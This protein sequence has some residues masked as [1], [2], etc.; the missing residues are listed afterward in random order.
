MPAA[1]VPAVGLE[2]RSREAPP[3]PERNPR[4]HI[5][6]PLRGLASLA[7]AWFHLAHENPAVSR[8]SLLQQSGSYGWIGV[9]AFFVISGFVIPF[10]LA[11]SGYT[12]H[13]YGR[14]LL[15]RVVRL[16]P[17]YFVAITV[18]LLIAIYG[19]FAMGQGVFPFTFRQILLHFG[20]L[21]VFFHYEWLNP[22]FWTLAVE[23]E[24]YVLI[25]LCFP[26]LR[27]VRFVWLVMAPIGLVL[28]FVP[29]FEFHVFRYLPFFFLG[30]AAYHVKMDRLPTP[31]FVLMT[32]TI[33]V[34]ASAVFGWPATI[35]ALLTSW[36]IVFLKGAPRPLVLLGSISYS[37]YLLHGPIG[38]TVSS[39]LVRRVPGLPQVVTS[40]TALA[41]SMVG[42]W[43][44]FR[45]V[46][47]PSQRLSGRIRYTQRLS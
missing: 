47:R 28:A 20:Y 18:S 10:A 5:L 32:L 9:E 7:V 45:L 8:G 40:L 19:W 2:S 34:V 12:L 26:L 35:A 39:I 29:Q 4:I 3:R 15:K 31:A 44:L 33:A 21:N 41:A 36:A 1:I 22:V 43:A 38:F 42:A 30:I 24:Y 25:G 11:S 23:V 6:D 17:P 37:L 13:D 16:D 14:F 27:K 46:E